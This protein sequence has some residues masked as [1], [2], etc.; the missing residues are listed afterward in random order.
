M[1]VKFLDDHEGEALRVMGTRATVKVDADETGGALELVVIDAE[2]GSEVPPHRHPWAET[3]YMISGEMEVRI[4]ARSDV[5]RSGAFAT[6]P[7]PRGPQPHRPVGHGSLPPHVHRCGRDGDVP[8]ARQGV[9]EPAGPRGCRASPRTRTHGRRR[10]AASKRDVTKRDLS[11][12]FRLSDEF[13]A[14]NP[15]VDVSAVEA[16][17][18]VMA[19]AELM[20]GRKESHLAPFGLSKG[21]HNILNVLAGADEPLTPTQLGER[22]LVRPATVTGLVDTLVRNGHVERR[23]DPQNRR[24]VLVSITDAG[25]E[26]IANAERGCLCRQRVDNGVLDRDR[27]RTPHPDPRKAPGPTPRLNR[28][29]SRFGERAH[30]QPTMGPTRVRD[31]RQP[32]ARSRPADRRL[33]TNQQRAH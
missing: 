23:P 7:A 26:V 15:E 30:L 20:F 6:I 1:K 31:R 27:T 9:P 14:Q 13:V 12:G 18:N 25:R 19:V 17:I 21:G 3:Y 5:L 11:L 4:G 33:S 29:R 8:H 2:E 22:V 10:I 32:Q 28:L 16:V 24:R